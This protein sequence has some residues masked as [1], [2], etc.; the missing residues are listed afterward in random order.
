VKKLER[1]LGLV[2]VVAISISAMLGSG[3]FLLPGMAA[4]RTGSSVWV[5]YLLAGVCVVPAA[6]C[7]AELATA[8]PASGGSY[9]YL[10]RIFGPYVG[11]IA[12]LALWA[13]MLLKSAFALLGFG[14]Y[15]RVFAGPVDSGTLIYYALGML[16]VVVAI[17]LMGVRK[18]GRAQIVIVAVALLSMALLVAF[19]VA[20]GGGAPTTLSRGTAGLLEASA[21]VF[22]SYDG[23]TKVAAIAEEVQR[24][25]RNLP[26]GIVLSLVMMIAVYTLVAFVL[27]RTLPLDALQTDLKPIHSAA[28]KL[29]GPAIGIAAAVLAV[30]TMTSMAN[31]G[32]LAAS[33]FPFA[34]SRDRLLPEPLSWVHRTLHTPLAAILASGVVM[35]I[36][37]RFVPIVRVAKLASAVVIMIFVAEGLAVILFRESRA[38]W[39]RPKFHAPLYPILPGVGVLAGV[40]LLITLGPIAL[41]GAAIV[42]AVGTAMYFAYGRHHA[43]RRGVMGKIAPRADLRTEENGDAE[44]PSDEAVVVAMLGPERSP[45]M[46][47]DIGAA[48]AAGR[49][50]RAAHL[51]EV[52]EGG[53]PEAV[54]EDAVRLKSLE[55]R[56]RTQAE[57]QRLALEFDT[58]VSRDLSR[59]VHALTSRVSCDWLVMQWHGRPRRSLTS[60]TAMG[61]LLNNLESNL[62]MFRDAGVRYVRKILVLPA[63]GP[64]DALVV[65]TADDLAATWKAELHLARFV[66]DGAGDEAVEQQE[67]Y[68]AELERMCES[69]TVSQVARGKQRLRTLAELSAGYDLLV[70]GAPRVSLRNILLQSPEDRLT[71][72][73]ACSVLT[74]KSPRVQTHAAY[75]RR[76]ASA[77]SPAPPR[78]LRTY[79]VPE[80]VRACVDVGKKEALLQRVA[81]TLADALDGAGDVDARTILQAFREREREQNTAIG[82]GVA[83]PHG[84][85]DQL[86]RTVLAVFTLAHP[87]DYDAPDGAPIDVVFATVG[88]AAERDT[89]LHVLSSVARMSLETDLLERFRDAEEPREVLDAIAACEAAVSQERRRR[90]VV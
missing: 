43:K 55:R 79:V 77:T 81:T 39:Y 32:L 46:L 83:L 71:E 84:V 2:S 54:L 89:H 34:M 48:L 66:P 4:A 61:W 12:G 85:V 72:Q 30:L 21:F 9:V 24:P 50:I 19:G 16:V 80:A 26:L 68:L 57:E 76:T 88:P 13:S 41:I 90:D 75:S 40:G 6:L 8:M 78:G 10:D 45:E 14:E 38:Q 82:H 35:A 47:V 15:L 65:G 27:V 67:R 28:V 18:V 52:E 63:P 74:L 69:D 58:L 56:I 73:A 23:V 44:A 86:E 33:R 1:T 42:G 17:N 20:E 59:T 70:M 5:A 7:K 62:A 31:A 29:G 60:L 25:E 64:D 53:D 49:D 22:V 51:T 3:I 36:T 87:L 37:I 11:T